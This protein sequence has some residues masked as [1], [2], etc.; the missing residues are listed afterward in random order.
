MWHDVVAMLCIDFAALMA[1]Y[2]CEPYLAL[3]PVTARRVTW[4][5]VTRVLG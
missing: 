3:M 4:R 1:S 5:L 2:N